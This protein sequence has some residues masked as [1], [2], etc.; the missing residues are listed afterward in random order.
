[1]DYHR[2]ELLL[3]S[4]SRRG[5]KNISPERNSC[6]SNSF[7][8]AEITKFTASEELTYEA[9]L[10]HYRDMNNVID[11]AFS[12]GEIKGKAEGKA[13]GKYEEKRAIA[14]NALKMNIDDN[15][16]EQITGLSHLEIENIRNEIKE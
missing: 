2:K 10:M 13:E 1:M 8:V 5:N 4:L 3:D 12:D 14:I 6:L 9:S 16:I 11:T 7:E 15:V